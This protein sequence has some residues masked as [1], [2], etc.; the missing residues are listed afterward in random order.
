MNQKIK[1]LMVDDEA[2]FRAT[3]NKIL[4]RRGF[5]TVMAESGEEA[6]KKLSENPDVVIL[7]IKMPGMDGHQTLAEI[8]K[9][10]PNLPVIMLT[11]HGDL[12]SAR[13][14]Y[15]EGAFDYLSKPCDIDVLTGKIKDAVQKRQVPNKAPE[16]TVS[17]VMVP[18]SAYTTLNR[19]QTVREAIL[20]LKKTFASR[21]STSSIMETGHR[22]VIVLDE[23]QQV[24]GV[25]EIVNLMAMIMPAYLSAP[26]PS[27]ADTIQYS[28]MFWKGMFTS[29]IKKKAALPIGQVM[30]PAPYVIDGKASLMEACYMMLQ[31]KVRR[32]V[33]MVNG[34]V[35]GVIREQDL[36]FEMEKILEE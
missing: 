26:K 24:C 31:H 4:T 36:F 25:M 2:Q 35:G 29:E 18:I 32:L 10:H 20:E 23:R 8:R 3:T 11:G 17:G 9:T 7:D 13:Q 14:A 5:D 12:R 33:V 16:K 19:N 30:S 21:I 27:L 34:E 15:T 22:S 28:P 6:L 1:V